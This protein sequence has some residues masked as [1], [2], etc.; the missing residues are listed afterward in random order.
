M[1]K[2]LL[3]ISVMLLFS[4]LS[5]D[6]EDKEPEIIYRTSFINTTW[7]GKENVSY[8]TYE[9]TLSFGNTEGF[10]TVFRTMGSWMGIILCEYTIL[11]SNVLLLSATLEDGTSKYYMKC[12]ITS[13]N[14]MDAV[15]PS[16]DEMCTFTLK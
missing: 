16:G 12:T 13:R 11:S 8:G 5:C 14:T 10:C 1:K 7:E 4:F 6:K 9:I 15:Y 3:L 2:N